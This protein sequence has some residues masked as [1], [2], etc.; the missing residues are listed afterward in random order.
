MKATLFLL[1]LFASAYTLSL[2][3]VD[4]TMLI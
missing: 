4:L 1:A 2:A 3:D